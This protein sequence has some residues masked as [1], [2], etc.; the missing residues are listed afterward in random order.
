M[1]QPAGI[2]TLKQLLFEE[3]SKRYQELHEK[4]KDVEQKMEESL[5]AQ[6]LPNA[7]I[8]ALMDQ[9]MEV[10][11]ERLGPTIT[12][13]LKVQIKESRDDVVQ[14]LFPIIGQMIKKY[15]QQE[16]AVL[17]EKIDKQFEA[18]LSFDHLLLRIKAFFTGVKYSELVL[19]GTNEPQ[20]QEIFLID[21]ES[22]ILLASYSRHKSIDQD[23]VAGMLTAIKAFVEDAFESGDQSLETINYDLY[24]I[25]IQN[26][27]RFYISVV[28]SGVMDASFKSKLNDTILQFVKDVTIKSDQPDQSELTKKISQY[29]DKM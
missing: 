21:D 5:E 20:I 11:P 1:N 12:K 29:F 10:M 8:N 13:T 26:F 27:N 7:E 17:T 6:K 2:N 23:M 19:R 18:A 16:M 9:M 28:M 24:Q 14:A 3:E 4:I 15:V 22:G 25:Y